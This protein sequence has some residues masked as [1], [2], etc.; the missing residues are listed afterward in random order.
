MATKFKRVNV[1]LSPQLQAAAERLSKAA[2]RP[3]ASVL[4]DVL[5]E[6]VPTMHELAEVLEGPGGPAVVERLGL[7]VE[8]VRVQLDEQM[9]LLGEG[10]RGSR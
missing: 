7:F 5:E 10:Q 6:A 4:R 9:E 3:L 1:T 2:H 8:R